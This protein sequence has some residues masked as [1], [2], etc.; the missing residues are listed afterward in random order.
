MNRYEMIKLAE[1][2][3]QYGGSFAKAI[4]QAIFRADESNLKKLETTFKDLI[5]S[6]RRFL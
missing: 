5:E 6:Y 1:K 4:A 2:M 3:V